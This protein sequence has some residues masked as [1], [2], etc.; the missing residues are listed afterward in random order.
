MLNLVDLK[1][2]Y[3]FL[4]GDHIDAELR[5]QS[6]AKCQCGIIA[7]ELHPSPGIDGQFLPIDP[8]R[9]TSYKH[10]I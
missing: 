5:F 2:L 4:V 8:L 6:T 9:L 1:H 10:W 3:G 7:F